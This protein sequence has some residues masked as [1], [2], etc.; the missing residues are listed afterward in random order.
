MNIFQG[1]RR[2]QIWC[3]LVCESELESDC[4]FS[5]EWWVILTV[6]SIELMVMYRDVVEKLVGSSTITSEQAL[7]RKDNWCA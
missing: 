4:M 3:P 2:G 5:S 7:W 6:T 1:H